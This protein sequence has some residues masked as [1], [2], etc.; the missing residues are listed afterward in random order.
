MDAG[1][2]GSTGWRA[3]EMTQGLCPVHLCGEK[4]QGAQQVCGWEEGRLGIRD[5][6][7]NKLSSRTSNGVLV[8]A[9]HILKLE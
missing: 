9:A 2:W 7:L 3:A 5:L 6:V 4:I 1:G 8:S